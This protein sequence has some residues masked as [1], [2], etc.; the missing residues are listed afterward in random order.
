MLRRVHTAGCN[1]RDAC[2]PLNLVVKEPWYL[3]VPRAPDREPWL[4]T[5]HL[6]EE[7]AFCFKA[8][9]NIDS[10]AITGCR[11]LSVY[12]TLFV[13]ECQSSEDQLKK[14]APQATPQ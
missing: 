5:L 13:K 9:R 3:A 4:N 1:W 11:E 14:L 2:L 7:K 6:A 8:C 12:Y 10:R